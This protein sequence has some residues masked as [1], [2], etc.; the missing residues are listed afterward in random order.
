MFNNSS[1][2]DAAEQLAEQLAAEEEDG[3]FLGMFLGYILYAIAVLFGIPCNAF[4]LY[5][6]VRLARRYNELYKWVRG[7][8]GCMGSVPGTNRVP[9]CP[10]EL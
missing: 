8:V 9:C 7:G 6:M 3:L 10:W 2:A 1:A 4:V 5:R